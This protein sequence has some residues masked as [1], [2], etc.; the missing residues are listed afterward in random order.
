MKAVLRFRTVIA[1]YKS[2]LNLGNVKQW[3]EVIENGEYDETMKAEFRIQYSSSNRKT[4]LGLLTA[5]LAQ[6]YYILYGRDYSHCSV[7]LSSRH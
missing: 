4:S 5:P 2:N 3:K 1:L 6:K 7:M